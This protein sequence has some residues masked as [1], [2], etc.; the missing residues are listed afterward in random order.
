MHARTCANNGC[1]A[2]FV[3]RC[4]RQLWCGACLADP[5]ALRR[6]GR[7]YKRRRRRREKAAAE[8]GRPAVAAEPPAAGGGTACRTRKRC[9]GCGQVFRCRSNR[10]KWCDECKMKKREGGKAGK[11]RRREDGSLE[12]T[13]L[14]CGEPFAA[15]SVRQVRCPACQKAERRRRLTAYMRKWRARRKPGFGDTFPS[16]WSSIKSACIPTSGRPI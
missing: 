10:Q 15:A 14:G 8:A 5:E 4:N 12:K 16:S 1:G 13:C 6:R 3:P 7:E 11:A 2:E 9:A